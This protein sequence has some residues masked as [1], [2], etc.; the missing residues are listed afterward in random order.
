LSTT[1]TTAPLPTSTGISP[2][3]ASTTIS[4]SPAPPSQVAAPQ[5]STPFAQAT[6]VSQPI[7]GLPFTGLDPDGLSLGGVALLAGGFTL[8]RV[9]RRR[10][11]GSP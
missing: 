7:F 9:A 3:P 4:P 5:G 2:S 11:R 6:P 10:K 8:Q 1:T